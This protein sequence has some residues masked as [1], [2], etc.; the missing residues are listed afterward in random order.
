[1]GSFEEDWP[2]LQKGLQRNLAR[3]GIPPWKADDV[4]QE[5][6][7]RLF[8]CWE[9]VDPERSPFGL[10]LRIAN[11]L[12]WDE[13]RKHRGREIL[14]EVPEKATAHDVEELTPGPH[15]TAPGAEAARPAQPEP[16]VGV[17]GRGGGRGA[18]GDGTPPP[19][20]WSG[21][22]HASG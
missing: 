10:A 2:E 21:C 22:G 16:P 20:R 6:G 7:L 13:A 17:A 12:M 9:N 11:N 18:T 15:G 5:T 8:R 19:R 14:G 3:R 1:M 4:I